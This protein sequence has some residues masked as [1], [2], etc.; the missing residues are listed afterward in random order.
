LSG[1]FLHIRIPRGQCFEQ[2]L[3]SH[4]PFQGGWFPVRKR[5]RER[6]RWEKEREER[7]SRKERGAPAAHPRY[8]TR[9]LTAVYFQSHQSVVRRCLRKTYT[10]C[11]FERENL[12]WVTERKKR[13]KCGSTVPL[14]DTDIK[15]RGYAVR[16]RMAWERGWFEEILVWN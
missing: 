6:W 8:T 9:K 12:L 4:P 5:E 15:E 2:S 10:S 16:K 13:E 11:V 7:E 3:L 14:K 1:P